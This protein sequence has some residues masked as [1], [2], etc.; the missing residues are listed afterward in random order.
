MHRVT[1]VKGDKERLIAVYSY[2]ER[3][4]VTFSKEEQMG[5][6]GRAA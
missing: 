2:Y 1:P 5:F 6:Y 3:P 4:G